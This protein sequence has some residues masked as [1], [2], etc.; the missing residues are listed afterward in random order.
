MKVLTDNAKEYGESL[1]KKLEEIGTELIH[2]APHQQYQNR[3][4][5]RS[6]GLI[7][8][9][10][11]CL[12]V[13]SELKAERYWTHAARHATWILNNL[14]TVV[15]NHKSPVELLYRKKPDIRDFH[16][17]GSLCF[18]HS[19]GKGKTKFDP[20]A[21]PCRF[22]GVSEDSKAFHVERLLDNRVMTSGEVTFVDERVPPQLPTPQPEGESWISD[23]IQ[24]RSTTSS[25]AGVESRSNP[26]LREKDSSSSSSSSPSSSSSSDA[27]SNSSPFSGPSS[28]SS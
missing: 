21:I 7:N 2:S 17:F 24:W 20:K 23:F 22:L 26:T 5:E 15:L 10:V 11:R 16:R 13:E 18:L 8:D 1:K 9:L 3:K 14:P 12:L 19:N 4:S 6:V 25:D 27:V 28:H